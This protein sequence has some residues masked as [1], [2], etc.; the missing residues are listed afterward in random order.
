MKLLLLILETVLCSF[1][2]SSYTHSKYRHCLLSNV[3]TFL[4]PEQHASGFPFIDC[5]VQ[6][7]IK[8]N[9]TFYVVKGEF[10]CQINSSQSFIDFD[11]MT[12]SDALKI[13]VKILRVEFA[14]DVCAYVAKELEL[15]ESFRVNHYTGNHIFRYSECNAS[16]KLTINIWAAKLSYC[17]VESNL[18]WC[19]T[20]F[21]MSKKAMKKY[22]AADNRLIVHFAD[23]IS[24]VDA[25]LELL[26][27]GND[28]IGSFAAKRY[29]EDHEDD[30]SDDDDSDEEDESDEEP[31]DADA[32]TRLV[33]ELTLEERDKKAKKTCLKQRGVKQT[34]NVT[35]NEEVDTKTYTIKSKLYEESAN[36]ST[37][38]KLTTGDEGESED[39]D[40]ASLKKREFGESTIIPMFPKCILDEDETFFE[41]S[42]AEH[43]ELSFIVEPYKKKEEKELREVGDN[44]AVN[45]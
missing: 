19:K 38:Q 35:F 16:S 9:D 3:T 13:F 15:D 4:T 36:P 22:K 25:M 42:N 41:H 7:I 24:Y 26:Y 21:K 11:L 20:K 30:T 37:K 1:K 10:G 8:Y 17:D 27:W 5:K 12:N 29:K 39:E 14:L 6:S 43:T 45:I 23:R 28:D 34:N 2:Y 40:G 44:E 33:E 32:T 31:C 18:K